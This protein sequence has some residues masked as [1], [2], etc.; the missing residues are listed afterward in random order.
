[1]DNKTYTP[2]PADTGDVVLTS[3]IMDLAELL[4]ENTHDI[5]AAN[6]IADGW[7]YGPARDDVKKEN[8]CLVPYGE[9]PESEKK[10]DR[11][12]ALETL[13]LIVKLGY[14]ITKD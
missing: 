8:P 11:D 5:W 13:R 6:R 7:T 3:D 1:M 2:A 10:Y 4:A 12:T 9:L 14:R